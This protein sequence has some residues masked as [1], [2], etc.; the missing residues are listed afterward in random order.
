MDF[1]IEKPNKPGNSAFKQQKI[2]SW[3]FI[4]SKKTL[5][6]F[7]VGCGIF[8][9]VIGSLI[10]VESDSVIE[11]KLRYDSIDSCK[12][13]WLNPQICTLEL[14]LD[15]KMTKPVFLYY[16]LSNMY[17]NHRIYNKNRDALQLMG[18]TRSENEISQ[19]CSPIK[20][21]G[22]LGLNINNP[23][24]SPLSIANPCGLIAKSVFNDTYFIA[25][26]NS[27]QPA[28]NLSTKDI[29]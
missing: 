23:N 29:S 16:E 3:N 15:K 18:N 13:T 25:P 26:I 19:Y 1:G 9:L 17:Q 4:M 11:H 22:E 8:F 5:A 21:M 14:T 24:L 7:Y 10:V 20:T 28:I 27:A 6:L 2:K 12:A